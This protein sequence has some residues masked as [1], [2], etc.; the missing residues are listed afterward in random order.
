MC[1]G[2]L[3]VYRL[4]PR[5]RMKLIT[6]CPQ[7]AIPV[8]SLQANVN[9]HLVSAMMDRDLETRRWSPVHRSRA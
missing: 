9:S 6:A 3:S 8:A 5:R 2:G 4:L 1:G 7:T